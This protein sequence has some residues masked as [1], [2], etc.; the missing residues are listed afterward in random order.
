M[1]QAFHPRLHLQQIIALWIWV[2]RE[3][4]PEGW[5]RASGDVPAQAKWW[6]EQGLTTVAPFFSGSLLQEPP[7]GRPQRVLVSSFLS[8]AGI[9]SCR[10]SGASPTLHL[11]PAFSGKGLPQGNPGHD[12]SLGSWSSILWKNSFACLVPMAL[13]FPILIF[14]G[15]LTKKLCLCIA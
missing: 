3:A 8:P 10:S 7:M 5:C 11:G 12:G 1:L 14:S 15:A 9:I 6:Q 13:L 2:S 4:R